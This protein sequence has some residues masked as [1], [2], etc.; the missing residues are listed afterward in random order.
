VTSGVPRP[1]LSPAASS[2]IYPLALGAIVAI[3]VG[4]AVSAG[5]I[6]AELPLPP[7]LIALAD[8]FDGARDAGSAAMRA[9]DGATV[10]AGDPLGSHR[11]GLRVQT[12]RAPCAGEVRGV[13]ECGAV[14]LVPRE[15][16]RILR[17]ECPGVVA[18]IEPDQ[19]TIVAHVLRCC[20]AL[21][22]G[23][24]PAY[25]RLALATDPRDARVSGRLVAIEHGTAITAVPHI[26]TVAEL[27]AALR[28]VAGPLI[29]GT[30]AESVA[31]DMLTREP[32]EQGDA[33]HIV[34]VL[35]GPGDRGRGEQAIERLRAFEGAFLAVDPRGGEMTI[36]P[37]HA[38][39]AQSGESPEDRD[40]EFVYV[41][42]ARWY[43]PCMVD[44]MAEV[45][46]LETGERTMIVRTRYEGDGAART[47]VEN[48]AKC[49]ES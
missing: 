11:T 2:V 20:L 31:W 43:A 28:R 35:L 9:L 27:A 10:A 18:T 15:G 7:H 49:P 29:I 19:L 34:A 12:L 33:E 45:G 30:V 22:T 32:G 13:P 39:D 16:R 47:P 36:F 5:D 42:P 40:G 41:D 3:R 8:L 48:V 24:G 14:C 46:L 21:A 23:V 25:G 26:A 38:T 6:V 37:E 4:E 17:A 44:G 1:W